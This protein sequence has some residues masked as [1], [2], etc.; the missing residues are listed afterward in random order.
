MI[1]INHNSAQKENND[2]RREIDSENV[3]YRDGR[4]YRDRECR[5]PFYDRGCEDRGRFENCTD[6]GCCSKKLEAPVVLAPVVALAGGTTAVGAFPCRTAIQILNNPAVIATY[7]VV[8]QSLQKCD[9][10]YVVIETAGGVTA[11]SVIGA[12]NVSP[13]ALTTEGSYITL[14]WIGETWTQI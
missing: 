4:Y 2:D 11:I 1:E 7:T 5:V 3:Y 12:N 6:G 10:G 8:L 9:E 14:K 13:S